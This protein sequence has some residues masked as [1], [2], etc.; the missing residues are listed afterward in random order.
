MIK[1]EKESLYPVYFK[2]PFFVFR[3]MDGGGGILYLVTTFLF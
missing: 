1:S 2:T 3:F